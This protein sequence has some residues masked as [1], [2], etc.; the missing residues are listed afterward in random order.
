MGANPKSDQASVTET[1]RLEA[2]S[3]GV[4]A[5]AITLLA[6]NLRVPVQRDL[7]NA[8]DLNGA[9]LGQWPQY[10]AYGLSFLS[11]LI[12][13]INHHHLFQVI[14]RTDHF[15]LLL[16]GLL[17][18]VITTVPFVTSLL[19]AYLTQ[20]DK[21]TAQVVFSGAYLLMAV[22]F[23]MM[24][25]YASGGKRLLGDGIDMRNVEDIT[26][27]FRFGPFV[28]LIAFALAFASAEGSLTLN[29]LL[30]VFYALPSNITRAL[31]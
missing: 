14:R 5:V 18:M 6:L 9:L 3:D 12:M 2:F 13:W 23:N 31:T 15:F 24:W 20:P 16:N 7:A 10:L 4:F 21:R 1:A 29:I 28:Y 19:A 8:H 11:I 26:R 17:L 25:R 27:Q 30:A 22:V